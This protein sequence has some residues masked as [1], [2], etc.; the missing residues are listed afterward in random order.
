MWY[1]GGLNAKPEEHKNDR[2]AHRTQTSTPPRDYSTVLFINYRMFSKNTKTHQTP[3]PMHRV[4]VGPLHCRVC[5][6]KLHCLMPFFSAS[7]SL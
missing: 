2:M 1:R 7:A 4:G 3:S 5:K 6:I